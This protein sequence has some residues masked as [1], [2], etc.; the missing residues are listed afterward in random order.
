MF[1]FSHS[2]LTVHVLQKIP[3]RVLITCMEIQNQRLQ[4]IYVYHNSQCAEQADVF[5]QQRQ[6]RRPTTW[7]HDRPDAPRGRDGRTEPGQFHSQGPQR[8]ARAAP[9][10]RRTRVPHASAGHRVVLR[11]PHRTLGHL[12]RAVRRDRHHIYPRVRCG[13]CPRHRGEAQAQG[14]AHRQRHDRLWER[15]VDRAR[16][17][18]L[19][20]G[21]PDLALSARVSLLWICKVFVVP[22]FAL[23]Y[24]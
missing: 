13:S 3:D 1:Y 5:H 11:V 19:H 16:R 14:P 6:M 10:G 23:P 15:G 7:V 12:P 17:H 8:P 21:C 24:D 9:G 2:I 20:L 4:N 22:P 18:V